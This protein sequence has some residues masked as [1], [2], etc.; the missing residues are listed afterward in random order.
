MQQPRVA[1]IVARFSCL[2]VVS[3]E[4]DDCPFTGDSSILWMMRAVRYIGVIALAYALAYWLD[5]GGM[6]IHRVD[7]DKAVGAYS[8]NPTPE[9]QV[10]LERERQINDHI[11]R[12][13]AAIFA[14]IE[15]GFAGGLWAFLTLYYQRKRGP[16]GSQTT[17]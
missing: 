2:A 17:Q 13:D 11:R 8:R 15:V 16:S 3:R 14:A 9:N 6:F 7:F 10:A 12:H 5:Y 4:D 1:K